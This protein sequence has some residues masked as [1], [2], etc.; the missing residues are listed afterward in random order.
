MENLKLIFTVASLYCVF[1]LSQDC[2]YQN[3]QPAYMLLYHNVIFEGTIN[4]IKKNIVKVGV[5]ES[6][7]KNCNGTIRLKVHSSESQ[8]SCDIDYELK[9][10]NSYIF[11]PF[12]WSPFVRKIKKVEVF[13][14]VNDNVFINK[15]YF[16]NMGFDR[17]NDWSISTMKKCKEEGLFMTL[18]NFKT[19][20]NKVINCFE[21]VDRKRLLFQKTEP[22][23]KLSKIESFLL[24]DLNRLVEV[25]NR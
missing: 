21:I 4:S 15:Y 1:G 11:I 14:I 10:G 19:F 17:E 13:P 6:Y 16:R 3:T 23:T 25:Q 7:N 2:G 20:V 18:K 24:F 9:E 22:L 12:Y 8:K 5:Q